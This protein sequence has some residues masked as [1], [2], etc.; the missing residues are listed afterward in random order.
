MQHKPSISSSWHGRHICTSAPKPHMV[1]IK[2]T[3]HSPSAKISSSL[4]QLA[5]LL[6]AHL[7]LLSIH[8]CSTMRLLPFYLSL[9]ATSQAIFASS[10]SNGKDAALKSKQS[11]SSKPKKVVGKLV[12]KRKLSSTSNKLLTTKNKKIRKSGKSRNVVAKKSKPKRLTELLPRELVEIVVDYFNNDTYP[13]IVSTHNWLLESITG[14]A[15]DS[16]R[17]YVLTRSEGIKGLSHSPADIK[18]DECHLVDLGDSRWL[19]HHQSSSAHDGRYLSFSY[20]SDEASTEHGEQASDGI[21]R[22]TTS[23]EP[24]NERLGHV[25]SDGEYLPSGFLS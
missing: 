19:N 9:F 6:A 13:F 14:I 2:A 10:S 18:E 1:P 4:H 17:L 21:K 22:F 8:L 23:D 3:A 7:K 15:V 16:A 20:Y 25:K 5:G 11:G 24:E 12:G